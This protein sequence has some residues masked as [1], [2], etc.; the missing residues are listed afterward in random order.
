MGT[1][2]QPKAGKIKGQPQGTEH[3]IGTASGIGDHVQTGSKGPD[4]DA[5]NN[6]AACKSEP[7]RSTD[8]GNWERYGSQ[9]QSQDDTDKYSH[10]IGFFQA[11]DGISKY[12]LHILDGSRF[13]DHCQTVT[14]L[15][16]KFGSSQQLHPGT[17]DTADIDSVMIAQT[18]SSQL[19][20]V[21]FGTG[22][23]DALRNQLAVDSIPIDIFLVPIRIL[24]FTEQYGKGQCVFFGCNNQ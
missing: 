1:C 17:I 5:Y 10:K 24:L 14:Q 4:Q 9:G 18:K 6:R 2:I 23:D 15:Q 13:A 3:Q 12:L 11:F 16:G 20:P 7:D 19:L 22:D 21:Q 8:T